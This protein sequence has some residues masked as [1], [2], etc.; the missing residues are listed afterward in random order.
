MF[1]EVR[2]S[3]VDQD[4]Y[5]RYLMCCLNLFMMII[6]FILMFLIIYFDSI[7]NLIDNEFLPKH[8]KIILFASLVLIFNSIIRPL[9]II[10]N[11]WKNHLS[12]L[13]IFRHLQ[14]N[15][16]S[17]HGLTRK[18]YKKLSILSNL[19]NLMLIRGSIPT[20]ASS[21][22]FVV[23]YIAIKSNKLSFYLF[24]LLFI[25]LAFMVALTFML[26]SSMAVLTLYYFTLLF[27]QIN[28]KIEEIYLRSNFSVTIKDQT[29]LLRLIEEHDLKAQDVKRLNQISLTCL[30]FFIIMAL[31]QIIPLNLLLQTDVWYQQIIYSIY[32]FSTL[33]FGFGAHFVYSI[34]ISSAHKPY[35]IIY[36]ILV[37]QKL[38]LKLKWK[39]F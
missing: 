8:T 6:G 31:M 36:K 19:V 11:E 14:E 38:K 12:F 16:K 25:Y 18:N 5:L 22:T 15:N 13:K 9:D 35:K 4:S 2:S 17:K 32:L 7:F 1:E 34:Q 37:R 10:I 21:L 20:L 39:V 30:V 29:N 27:D 26:V 23:I 3:D 33:G 24:T 28:N